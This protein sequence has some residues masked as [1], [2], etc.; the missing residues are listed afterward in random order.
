MEHGYDNDIERLLRENVDDYRMYP[1][2]GVWNG[3]YERLHGRRRILI[4]GAI[5]LCLLLLL[6]IMYRER[7]NVTEAPVAAR[8]V[9]PG[10]NETGA[11]AQNTANN[12]V[13]IAA[14]PQQLPLNQ[15]ASLRLPAEIS[16]IRERHPL[17]T[18]AAAGTAVETDVL[19]P[20]VALRSEEN[21]VF[22][23]K[24]N[25]HEL[26]AGKAGVRRFSSKAGTV[27]AAETGTDGI[28][29]N[30][31]TPEALIAD[32]TNTDRE[33]QNI[34]TAAAAEKKIQS[35]PVAKDKTVKTFFSK[36]KNSSFAQFYVSPS[37]SYRR[38]YDSRLKGR[39]SAGGD[40]DKAV[41]HRPDM[42][43]EAGV[44]WLLPVDSRLRIKAGLQFNYNRYNIKASA[45]FWEPV[46]INA[47]NRDVTI[48]TPYRNRPDGVF[49]QW[50][51]NSNLQVSIPLGFEVAISGSDK[52]QLN[53]GATLQPSY[54]LRD[55]SYILSS[56]LKSYA[57]SE[58][59]S[60]YNPQDYLI[61]RLNV[62]AG[63][64]AFITVNTGKS[65][66]Q[67]GPQFR[68]Q[69]FSSYNKA[70]PIKE[71]LIDYGFKI[72]FSRMRR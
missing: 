32:N 24:E 23:E 54:L 6:L 5:S 48:A 60:K 30:I 9:K 17:N 64:E 50:L 31:I 37:I 67:F 71:R 36:A 7:R 13:S 53:I 14:L 33:L 12:V 42:G 56:D 21:E 59:L 57:S 70:N 22:A 41:F 28:L 38:L 11:A 40:L 62:N 1:S 47:S 46:T 65:R 43:L 10:G 45:T 34:Q 27:S 8:T 29:N 3:V 63:I 2:P 68:Y 72:G 35:A 26:L 4:T 49:P 44:A 19:P 69:L 39:T 25:T 15:P 58:E 52:A 61:R 20:A 18:N 55:K 16:Q 66:W 51:E